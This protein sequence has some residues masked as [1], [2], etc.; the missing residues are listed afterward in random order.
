MRLGGGQRRCKPLD[1]GSVQEE[2]IRVTAKA[3][4]YVYYHTRQT[5]S[6]RPFCS[7]SAFIQVFSPNLSPVGWCPAIKESLGAQYEMG[8]A[9]YYSN[10]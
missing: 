8:E 4:A 9:E 5:Q 1:R 6:R 2:E 7:P 3:T 10:R